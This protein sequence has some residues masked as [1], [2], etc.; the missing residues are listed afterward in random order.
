MQHIKA[1]FK[2]YFPNIIEV[3]KVTSFVSLCRDP[4][5]DFLLA[6][7]QD[8][9]ADYLITGD[10]DLLAIGRFGITKIVKMSDFILEIRV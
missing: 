2:T 3:I 8:G 1:E 6:L 9:S 7:S 4:K 10:A 5:D